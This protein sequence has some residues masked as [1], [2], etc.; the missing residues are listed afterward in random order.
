M[1]WIVL[2]I[3]AALEAVWATALGHTDGFTRVVPILLFLVAL[4]LSM[5]GLGFAAKHIPISTAYA[6]WT[7]TGAA[8]TVTW[9]VLTGEET[10]TA[11]RL[12]LLGGIVA[13]VVGL[14]LIKPPPTPAPR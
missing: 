3:S 11:V 9:A 12:L 10:A 7:G 4:A 8:L 14:K 1:P 2:M 13:A 5:A 6:V